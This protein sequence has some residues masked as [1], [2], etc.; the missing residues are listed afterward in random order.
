MSAL[1]YRPHLQG[2]H[3][4][5]EHQSF[6]NLHAGCPAPDSIAVDSSLRIAGTGLHG[7]ALECTCT[8][9][10]SRVSDGIEGMRCRLQDVALHADECARDACLLYTS[11]AA[12][13]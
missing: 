13:E 10:R 2:M 12:D 6:C 11:D 5:M 7:E 1:A 9:L 4:C 8:V 3:T